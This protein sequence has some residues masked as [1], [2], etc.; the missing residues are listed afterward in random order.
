MAAVN[1]PGSLHLLDPQFWRHPGRY[2]GQCAL[3]TLS[4]LLVLAALEAVT[5]ATVIASL[6]ASAF[7]AFTMPHRLLSSP[8]H[9]VGGYVVGIVVGSL[10]RLCLEAMPGGL[11]PLWTHVWRAVVSALAVGLAVFGM[12]VTSTE[13]PPAASLALGLVLGE[14]SLY[15]IVVVLA[16]IVG[17]SA[18]KWVLRRWL[19]DL[20]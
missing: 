3:A 12:V 18:L 17:L 10:C 19:I 8:R 2:I 16:G 9:L 15:V 4:M 11:P 20:V 7:V 5:H 6:G 1:K 13:H 14:T